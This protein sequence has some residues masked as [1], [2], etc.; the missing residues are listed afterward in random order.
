MAATNE[1]TWRSK[2]NNKY[3]KKDIETWDARL[4]AELAALRRAAH[5]SK[6]FDCGAL[7]QRG[8]A[9][10]LSSSYA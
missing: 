5:K 6:C 4:K 1:E 7:I 10:S 2:C 8:Q 3:L 9:L